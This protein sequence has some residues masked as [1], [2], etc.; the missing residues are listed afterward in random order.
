VNDIIV[1]DERQTKFLSRRREKL[2]S[3]Q[4]V[5]RVHYTVILR[6]S[7]SGVCSACLVLEA[8]VDLLLDPF[9]TLRLICFNIHVV[10]QCC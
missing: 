4:F 2:I 1:L 9:S 8:G 10:H 6:H 7:W 3:P 5:S